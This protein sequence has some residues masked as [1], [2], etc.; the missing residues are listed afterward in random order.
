MYSFEVMHSIVQQC[1]KFTLIHQSNRNCETIQ[2]RITLFIFRNKAL[3]NLWRFE[4]LQSSQ[5]RIN[6]K[7][8]QNS[9]HQINGCR[10]NFSN[11]YFEEIQ[12]YKSWSV[13]ALNP[14]QE[15]SGDS[16][17]GSCSINCLLNCYQI[18]TSLHILFF[19]ISN[20][21]SIYELVHNPLYSW[22]NVHL[23]F[24]FS[25]NHKLWNTIRAKALSSPFDFYSLN[26]WN[27]REE[28]ECQ[29][30]RRLSRFF[31]LALLL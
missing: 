21:S 15:E 30:V 14:L 3:W 27:T 16:W 22:R 12:H 8:F 24:L 4:V 11:L 7:S 20:S 13:F 6:I 28:R 29:I 18:H 17:K 5:P 2:S 23:L 25:S 19:N 26:E 9:S 31:F 10:P 1:T